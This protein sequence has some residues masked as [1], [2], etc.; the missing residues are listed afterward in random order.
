MRKRGFVV[1][2]ILGGLAGLV[3]HI[4][5]AWV[6]PHVLPEEL[7]QN[8]RYKGTV[9]NGAISGLDYL[10]EAQFSLCPKTWMKGG[11]PLSFQTQ[12]SAIQISGLASQ[13]ALKDIRFAGELGGL[14]TRDGRLKDLIGQVDIRIDE[15]DYGKSCNSAQ[16][17]AETDFLMRNEARWQWRGPKLS[18]PISCDAGDMIVSLAGA[19]N[20]QTI[21]ADLRLSPL[22]TYNAEISVRT[23]QPGAGVVLPLYGFEQRGGEFKLT[24]QGQWR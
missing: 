5:L 13:A 23:S 16:G 12:S 7:G 14:P 20:R 22:G 9:W 21:R 10:G 18:G 19:E 6:G 3:P 24:E 8:I 11:L 2:A 15:M 1:S 4:P 17:R